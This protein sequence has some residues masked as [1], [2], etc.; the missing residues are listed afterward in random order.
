MSEGR[1]Q[2]VEEALA[3]LRGEFGCDDGSFLMQLR[4]DLEWDRAA[5]ARL[6]AALRVVCERYDR[7]E[8]SDEWLTESC[9][10]IPNW[11]AGHTAHPSFP[12]PQPE[13][14]YRDSLDR[15]RALA[16]WFLHGVPAEQA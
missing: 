6:E 14:Y 10:S 4:I 13:S 2:T 12:R 9:R 15:L 7:R 16:A 8:A 1:V 3:V 5:F 11:V